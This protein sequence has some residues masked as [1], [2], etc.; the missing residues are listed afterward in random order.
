MRTAVL[1]GQ[2][3]PR[4]H[5]SFRGEAHA[6]IYRS[7]IF[8]SPFIGHSLQKL[9]QEVAVRPVDLYAFEASLSGVGSSPGVQLNVFSELRGRQLA[10]ND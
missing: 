5:R 7:S 1:S 2:W 9:V 3:H 6:V 10:R 4:L 8:I